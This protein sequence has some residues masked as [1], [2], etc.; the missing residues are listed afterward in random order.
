MREDITSIVRESQ[1][2]IKRRILL[3][4]RA[5]AEVPEPPSDYAN[6]KK[7]LRLAKSYGNQLHSLQKA[8]ASGRRDA[9]ARARKR[10]LN[11]FSSKFIAI[12]RG[13]DRFE[14][15]LPFSVIEDRANQLHLGKSFHETI[16]VWPVRSKPGK[17]RLVGSSGGRRRAQQLIVRDIL[18]A[19]IGDSECD[20]TVAGTG[21]E[22]RLFEDIKEAISDGYGH[23]VS[24]DILDF[25]L[26]LK[27]GHLAGFPLSKWIIENLV[28][29][30]SGTPIKFADPS[31]GVQIS[32]YTILTGDDDDLPYGY[33]YTMGAIRSKFSMVRQ[34]LIQGDVCA[35][36]IART[37]LGRELQRLLGKWD[38]AYVSHLDD[39]LI[40]ARTHA[41]LKAS[42]QALT[43]R[44]RCHPAGPLELHDH[45]IRSIA[46]GTYFLGYR[47]GYNSEGQLHVR[48]DVTRFSR[49]RERLFARLKESIAYERDE[50]VAV[51]SVYA[52]R[53][54]ASQG[55]WTKSDESFDY[56]MA[57]VHDV[58]NQFIRMEMATGVGKWSQYDL[59]D[60]V[61]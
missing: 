13:A 40:G 45:Q 26:S 54:F 25:F 35:P 14:G 18:L 36:Q 42:L 4:E 49:F 6:A 44:L 27:P 20:R 53:W 29:L 23:W 39:M 9:T 52:E 41:E 5:L 57:E 34:G 3:N 33:P 50:L 56:V 21:G 55:A 16:V 11:D 59:I 17:L 24:L 2:S 51:G 28:F 7:L 22:V 61:D 58:V 31:Y 15:Y 8:Y 10:V 12:I 30:P 47:I 38:V 60:A 19:T 37:F 48:P 43:H 46:D 32:E 1:R